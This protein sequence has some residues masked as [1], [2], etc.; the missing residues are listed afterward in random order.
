MRSIRLRTV[1][2]LPRILLAVF[3]GAVCTG[4]LA[5]PWLQAHGNSRAAAL[6]Y[7]IFSP[8]CH[9]DPTRSFAL[10]GHACAV[11]HR[12]TGIYFGLFFVSLIPGKPAAMIVE[13]HRRRSWI[14]CA[15]VPMLLDVFLPFASLWTSTPVSRV[16]TGGLFGAMLASLLMPALEEVLKENSRA[17]GRFYGHPRG[18]LI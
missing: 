17:R 10:F 15:T 6:L 2:T 16:L 5:A 1:P 8:V 14:A 13:P 3:W 9:Q 7:L 4:I 18:G 11:C 12:C